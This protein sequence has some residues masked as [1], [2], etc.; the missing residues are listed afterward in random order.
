MHEKRGENREIEPPWTAPCGPGLPP[1][2]KLHGAQACRFG[3][4][5]R[6]AAALGRSPVLPPA[7]HGC[8]RNQA[9][10]GCFGR[11]RAVVMAGAHTGRVAGEWSL[12]TAG[13]GPGA[14]PSGLSVDRTRPLSPESFDA[15][16]PSMLGQEGFCPSSLC[17]LRARPL[18][19]LGG[20]EPIGYAVVASTLVAGG[21]CSISSLAGPRQRA[22][23]RS[24]DVAVAGKLPAN[25]ALAIVTWSAGL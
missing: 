12:I 4:G 18:R 1:L 24:G 13:D 8:A 22:A 10:R 19:P 16:L 14:G 21:C 17:R 15:I 3:A 25:Q 11:R 7:R 6:P 20:Q 5:A 2:R 9:A 23:G